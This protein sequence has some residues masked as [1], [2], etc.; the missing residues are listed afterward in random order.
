MHENGNLRKFL[1]NTVL[2]VS[3]DTIPTTGMFHSHHFPPINTLPYIS[4]LTQSN[5]KCD[6]LYL[7]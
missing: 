6:P 1:Q 4:Y 2:I 3:V 7:K 5:V